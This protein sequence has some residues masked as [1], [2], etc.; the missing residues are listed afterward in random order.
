MSPR[1][2]IVGGG[3]AG[4][5]AA[6]QLARR[7]I[8]VDLHEMRPAKPTPV[9]QT[10]DL[11]ELVC[12]NSLRGNALDQAAGLLK[13]EMRR[14]DSL[15]VRVADSVKVPAGSALAVDRGLFARHMT[16]AIEA[17]PLVR[18][19]RGEVTRIPDDPVAIVA[20]GPLTSE[21]L[22]DAIAA[23]VGSAHLHFF[24]AVSPV[25]EADSI[26]FA[27]AFRASRYGKGGDDYLN[28]PLGEAE[29]GAFY[30]ALTSAEC[31]R[32]HD[33]EKE[34]FFE[35]CLP[36]EVIASRGKDTL[37]FGPMKPVGLADPRSGRRPHAVV[38]LRQ[39]NLAASHWSIV[40]FQTQLKW[41]EQKRVFQLIPGLERAEFV[42]FGMIHRNTYVNAP[43]SLEP[44]FETRRRPGLFF[45]G[46]MS[47]VE[48]YVE[49][50]ASGLVAGLAASF[51]V[52]GKEPLAL[53]L[54]TALGALGR[55]IARSDPEH[56][57]PTNIAFGL[58]PEL[59]A[60]VRDKAKKRLALAERALASLERF[61][62]RLR[63]LGALGKAPGE[64]QQPGDAR[65]D[66]GVAGGLS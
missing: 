8:G 49:S 9:H 53:P 28:C 20:T 37:R 22:A 15:V 62:G 34:L 3:L 6:W 55:Y 39:D 50:A 56:Y 18:L 10:G 43:S 59:P 30:A 27:R 2:T 63:D 26:D 23:F 35:G 17:L 13:E 66:V 41:G 60:R 48:G 31:A 21:P 33:F 58:L 36:V 51:R 42:R 57:Q 64:E 7:G 12:S 52:R 14:L 25:V 32:V 19:V 40:G 16:E 1:V 11:A 38:Q 44:T 45:A 61:R 5:E 65:S 4:C 46:Q 29:Y 47:G 24:D 54:D